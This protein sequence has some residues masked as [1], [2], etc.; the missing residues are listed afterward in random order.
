MLEVCWFEVG[1]LCSCRLINRPSAWSLTAQRY[2]TQQLLAPHRGSS[3][4][5]SHSLHKQH[6]LF[7]L[8]D[9]ERNHQRVCS[10]L[11]CLLDH[12]GFPLQ[13]EVHIYPDLGQQVDSSA[14]LWI[15]VVSVLA[16]VLLLALICL[17]LWKVN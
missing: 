6:D 2:Y 17:L 13:I 10:F 5:Y 15:I 3:V 1:R 12:S 4:Y 7:T 14:P 9:K 11:C 16:G 8:T